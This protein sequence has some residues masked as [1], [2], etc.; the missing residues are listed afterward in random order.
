MKHR[1]TKVLINNASQQMQK[2]NHINGD[3]TGWKN[4]GRGRGIN[5]GKQCSYCNKENHATNELYSKHG[6]P[7]WMKQQRNNYVV[8]VVE[9]VEEVTKNKLPQDKYTNDQIVNLLSTEQV[10]K[11]VY[12]LQFSNDKEKSNGESSI[13]T[14][15][16][17]NESS[18]QTFE[19]GKVYTNYW[20]LDTGVTYHVSCDN[21]LFLSHHEIKVN[22]NTIT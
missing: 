1:E 20:I 18:V 7:L 4:Y 3:N 5:C 17:G 15:E 14:F 21:T 2:P 19:K 10:R 11:I 9:R 22:K 8:Y 16:K 12:I 6:F 13:Q